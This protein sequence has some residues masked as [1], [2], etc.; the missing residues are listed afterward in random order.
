MKIKILT[1]A[2]AVLTLQS[3]KEPSENT[4]ASQASAE[5]TTDVKAQIQELENAY[6]DA[7]NANNPAEIMKYYA[8]DAVSYNADGPPLEGKNAIRSDIRKSSTP[9][10]KTAKIHFTVQEVLPSSDL[11]QVVELGRY[12]IKDEAGIAFGSGNYFSLF[13][14]RDGKYVCIRDMQTPDS[15]NRKP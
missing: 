12:E 8:N 4:D 3:C 7:V 9:F 1:F 5:E 13:Q 6:A 2:L 14:K 15:P 10:P 11:D